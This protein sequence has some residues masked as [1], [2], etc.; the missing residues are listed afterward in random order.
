MAEII[1]V[2]VEQGST[3]ILN[4][5][6]GRLAFA[7]PSSTVDTA[8]GAPGPLQI[9]QAPVKQANQTRGLAMVH[10]QHALQEC[11]GT[12]GIPPLPRDAVTAAF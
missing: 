2:H 12:K 6:T 4:S 5:P 11:R 8:Q 1:S 3:A 10:H 7:G 9:P